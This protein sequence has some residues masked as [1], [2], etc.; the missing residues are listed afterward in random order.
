MKKQQVLPIFY[1]SPS[2][3]LSVIVLLLFKD[4]IG[5]ESEDITSL[6][7]QL[8]SSSAVN[9]LHATLQEK[10]NTSETQQRKPTGETNLLRTTQ[11]TNRLNK[12]NYNKHKQKGK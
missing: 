7:Y 4:I 12:L 1:I 2:L 6:S 11:A 10:D 5:L 3:S 9:R 8:K